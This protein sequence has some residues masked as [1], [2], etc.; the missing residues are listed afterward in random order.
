MTLNRFVRF[1]EDH[2]VSAGASKR[3]KFSGN[4]RCE[5]DSHA[6]TGCAGPDC[7]VEYLRNERVNV[8]PFSSE[9]AA[10]TNVRIGT[11]IY[12][13]EDPQTGETVLL[14]LHEQ[15]IFGDRLQT[16]LLNPNQL[17]SYGVKVNECPKQFDTSS[18]HSISVPRESGMLDIPL[19]LD[20]IISFFAVRK[21]TSEELQHCDRLQCTSDNPWDPNSSDWNRK[22][23]DAKKVFAA[24][25]RQIGDKEEEKRLPAAPAYPAELRLEREEQARRLCYLQSVLPHQ[26]VLPLALSPGNGHSDC[27][28]TS[29]LPEDKSEN[30]LSRMVASVQIASSGR[31]LDGIQ[32]PIDP[33]KTSEFER[34]VSA[35][36]TAEKHSGLT[37]EVL[38]RRWGTSLETAD[39]TLK[40]TTQEGITIVPRGVERR[41]KSFSKHLNY[42]TLMGRWY[43]DTLFAKCRSIRNYTCGQVFTN[44][45]GD[46]FMY[47]LRK[48]REAGH[49]LKSFILENGAMQTLITDNAKEEGKHG[50]H[51]TLWNNLVDDYM[52]R[53]LTTAPYSQYQN[54][55]ESE[56]RELKRGTWKFLRLKKA[57]KRLWC[58]CAGWYAGVRRLTALDIFRLG[59]RV[60]AEKRLGNT[61][62][63]SEYAQFDWYEFVKYNDVGTDDNQH[64][65]YGRVLG[66]CQT[67]GT[68]MCFYILT[69]KCSVIV[70]DTVSSLSDEESRRDDMEQRIKDFDERVNAKIGDKPTKRGEIAL[71]A[72]ML[73]DGGIQPE[74]PEELFNTDAKDFDW[75]LEEPDAAMPDVDDYDPDT[76]D[77]YLN[78]D[79]VM[80]RGDG[81][82]RGKVVRRSHGPDMNPIGKANKNP[83]LDTRSY[84]VQFEDGEVST[85]QANMIAEHMSSRCDEHGHE[86]MLMYE[87]VD[88][89]KNGDAVATA[90]G[91]IKT[92]SGNMVPRKTTKGWSLL[93]NWKDKS[94]SWVAL[95][96]LKESHPVQVA[97]YA[98]GNK[99]TDEPAFKWWV[100]AVLKKRDRIIMK[101]K[102]AY[103]RKTHKYGIRVPRTVE[104]AYDIDRQ[105]GNTY[106][107]DAINKEMKNVRV[108]F[109]FNDGDIVPIGHK[110]LEVHMIFDVKMMTLQRKARLVAGGH[111]TDP[112][113]ETVYSSVVS[114]ESV[115]LAFLAAALNDL[116]ILAADIQNAYL[117]ASTKEKLYCV[118]GKEFGSDAGR[119]A[120]IVRALYGLRSSGKMFREHLART[121]REDMK[122]FSCKADPDVWMR[123]ATKPDGTQY[124]EYILCYVDDVLCISHEPKKLLDCIAVNFTLKAGSVKE[125]DL[126]LG[127]EISKYYI[128][129]SNEPTKVRWAMSSDSYVK[130]AVETVEN[131]LKEVKLE[132]LPRK[133]IET[134]ISAGYKPELDSTGELDP[135]RL[136]YFQG[137][138]GVLRWICELGR[139]DIVLP[140]ALLSRYLASPRW[141]HL[142]QALHIFAYLKKYNR[143]KMV[144]D[145]TMPD[146]ED[147]SNFVIGDWSEVYP[148]A[149]E[150]IPLDQP[151]A[152]GNPVVMSC[153][154]DADHAGD[155]VNRRSQTGLIVFVNRAPIYWYSKKQN[156][157]E[158]STFGSEMVAMKQSVEIIEGLRYKIR[159]MGF[160][161]EGPCNVFCDNNAVVQNTSRPESTLKKKHLSVSYHRCREAQAAG[162]IRIAKE[163]TLTNIAD[164]FTKLLVG[165]KLREL[166][167]LCLW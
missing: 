92:N 30:M 98:E 165:T 107:S 57:P 37:K 149:K 52:I 15:L 126:Y 20:G 162:T 143:S 109:E 89:R 31:M 26:D 139:L 128:E 159:M 164:M 130:N 125:P 23:S 59:G 49:G 80:P 33:S 4:G 24:S 67:S 5:L 141:G 111:K 112:P 44:G 108:A 1:A 62:D 50:A 3:V 119:P 76:V 42:P 7:H 155:V 18:P 17:R 140:V 106:W 163:G 2:V 156:T 120:K 22:E 53:H 8:Y 166:C 39:R 96:D 135:V 97:E 25:T 38:A 90:D 153:F 151:Q 148:G 93:V 75:D 78:S 167:G 40:V 103:R 129:E 35:T 29:T 13:V 154:E 61:P 118:V 9:S 87:I 113:K 72:E 131:S 102:S 161:L 121:L 100:R 110:P 63:I 85:Y 45:L 10:V 134:P 47:P 66:P 91:M 54:R 73:V 14:V 115:R 43:S 152:R 95:K 64:V 137:L 104:D 69:E 21:P 94:S 88:H 34:Q 74:I 150:T 79:V 27:F 136:N 41:F 124:W 12:A 138:I 145:E 55:A 127:A 6:D 28:K 117:S 46:T 142:E 146:F 16:S 19:E 51:D 86:L 71:D 82:E 32:A 83:I 70:R 132:F 160:P 144:F 123:K 56:I 77:N 99:I 105:N 157:V 48:K 114:R 36:R 58:F 60:P 122:F 147:T 11:V 68:N 81:F 133:K 116:D 84:E 65:K 158:S 101:V